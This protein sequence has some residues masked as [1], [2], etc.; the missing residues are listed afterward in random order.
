MT[1]KE[2]KK[3]SPLQDGIDQLINM[4]KEKISFILPFLY[5]KVTK[6]KNLLLEVFQL[7][8]AEGITEFNYHPF[9]TA[10]EIMDPNH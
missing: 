5:P 7:I 2:K 1:P 3:W 6:Y 9:A 4:G 10:N 8:N